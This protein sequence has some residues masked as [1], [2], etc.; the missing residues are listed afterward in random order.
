MQRP[1][2]KVYTRIG[3]VTPNR[4]DDCAYYVGNRGLQ[5]EGLGEVTRKSLGETP[6]P[7]ESIAD[8]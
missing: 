5:T 8:C 2:W 7:S 6:R 4:S 3:G 1:D